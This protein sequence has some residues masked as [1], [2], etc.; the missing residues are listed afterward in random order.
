MAGYQGEFEALAGVFETG[1]ANQTPIAWENL[2]FS[3]PDPMSSW[4]RFSVLSGEAF[5]A[6][7][8]AP[9]NN[10]IRHPGLIVVQVFVPLNAGALLTLDLADDAA[11][12]FRD[13]RSG[14][15]RCSPPWVTTIRPS[16]RDGWHQ[17]NVN[18]PFVRDEV[19]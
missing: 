5:Y 13:Y 1:W 11:G 9:G 17:V 14:G 19:L 12:I 16:A 18:I 10:V 15:V 8:G 2:D 4:V 7:I 3:P 6:S